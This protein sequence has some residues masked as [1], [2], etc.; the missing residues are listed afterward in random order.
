MK[1]PNISKLTAEF[2]A[3]RRA[4]TLIELLVVI[5]IIAILAAMLLPA[6]SKAKDKAKRISCLSNLKQIGVGMVIY[7]LDNQDRV[8]EARANI[9]QVALNPPQADGAK[10]VGLT[11]GS[12][13]VAIWNCPGRPPH[14]PEYEATYDQWVIGYQYLG[15]ITNWINPSY[16]S[17]MGCSWSPIKLSSARPHWALAADVVI[18]DGSSPWGIFSPA[19]DRDIFDGVPPHRS[20]ASGMPAG[21][22]TV[23]A[24]GSGQWNKAAKLR[25]FHSWDIN[26]RRAYFY[27][28]YDADSDM[29]SS[30]V[31][32]LNTSSSLQ[33][34][35]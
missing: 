29:P 6:L 22:N 12:N 17:G 5:A 32:A 3:R 34:G 33:I 15:G 7:A 21:A 13:S 9:V 16:S 26:G 28:N 2:R 30:F 11:V 25:F 27:Q 10:T 31:T 4:F 35:P 14:Y 1:P 23:F 19:S 20:S 8:I 24:D 18:R